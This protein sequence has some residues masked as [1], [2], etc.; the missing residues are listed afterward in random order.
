M[1][2]IVTVKTRFDHGE[3]TRLFNIYLAF[4]SRDGL[5]SSVDLGCCCSFEGSRLGGDS[6]W[7]AISHIKALKRWSSL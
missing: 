6:S 5:D 7:F 2:L 3:T 4:D 1:S